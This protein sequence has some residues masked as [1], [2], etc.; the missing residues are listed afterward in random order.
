MKTLFK[1]DEVIFAVSWILIYIFTFSNAD[2]LS[3]SIGSP[4]SI[5]VCVGLFLSLLLI[6]FV[7]KNSLQEYFGLCH[8][9]ENYQK[10]AY[11]L[12]LIPISSINLLFGFRFPEHL[13]TAFLSVLCMCF[14]G[15][16]EEL[17]FRGFL[18]KAMCKS[19]VKA[20]IIV[21]SL[22]FGVGHII[23]LLLGEP[24]L[25]TLLQLAYASSVGFCYTAIFYVSGSIIPCI[26]SHALVNSLS[27]FIKDATPTMLVVTAVIQII[28]STGYG[29]WLLR[30]KHSS[31]DIQ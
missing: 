27:V 11:F 14:V 24:L 18:F 21:S 23:N 9:K 20:A 6:R 28:L 8:I 19:N 22:T 4:K 16:L 29:V 25:E 12:P 7:K 3:E 31:K 17:I 26:L 10:L 2:M 5:T 1:K 30:Q 13:L 15:F